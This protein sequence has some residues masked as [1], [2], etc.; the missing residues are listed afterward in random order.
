[1]PRI[2]IA[3]ALSTSLLLNQ[4]GKAGPAL[5]EGVIRLKPGVLAAQPIFYLQ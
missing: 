5:P 1:M 2:A 4:I 3:I